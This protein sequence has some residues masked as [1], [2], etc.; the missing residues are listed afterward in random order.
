[1]KP[2]IRLS[3]AVM[4]ALAEAAADVY[5]DT[6][7]SAPA[8]TN[9]LAEVIVTA[10]RRTENAQNVPI[11]LQAL[12]AET[13]TQLN[14]TTF[15]DYIKY[16]PNVT[17]QGLGPGQNNIYMRGL[18][19]AF[20]EIQGAGTLETF[21]NVAVYLDDQ[22]V[23]LP[24]RNLDIYAADLERIEV[25]EGPQGT[26]FGAGAQ[27]GVV[28]YITNK[29]QLDVIAGNV[30]AGYAT[31]AH[32]NPSSNAEGM[33]NLPIIPGTLAVRGVVYDEARG[34]YIN[35]IS[36]TFARQPTD[37]GILYAYHATPQNMVSIN[38]NNLAAS[39]IN[40]VTYKGLRVSALY[41]INDDWNALLTQSYQDMEADGV[42]AEQA[43]NSTG[44]PQPQLTVQLY[45]PSWNKDRFE[46]TSLTIN[47][48]IGDLKAVYTGAYFVRN[49][50]QVQDY[51]NYARGPYMDY[52]QCV[53]GN[54]AN[55]VPPHCYTPSATW[56]DIERNTHLSHEVRL[57]TPD[58]WRV[59]A[60]GGLFQENYNI[61]EQVDWFYKTATDY[62]TLIAPPLG[63]FTKNGSVLQG[64][65]DPHP[66]KPV[67][68]N[69]PGA[70][71]VPGP[72][73]SNN[74]N[75]RNIND[76]FFNDITRGYTQ[77][78]AFGSLDFDVV[79]KKLTLTV[80]TRYYRIEDS[81]RGSS[82]GSFGCKTFGVMAV[83]GATCTKVINGVTVSPVSNAYNLDSLHF[84]TV[85]TG[86]KSRANLTFKVADDAL[87]YYTW[88]QGFRAGGFNR[89]NSVGLAS[90]L[91][92]SPLAVANGG[93]N[94]PLVYNPDSLINNELGWK[95]EWWERRVQWNGAIYQ[96]NWKN[97]QITIFDPG[98]TGNL[99][100]T[101]NGG[102]YKVK[103]LETSLTARVTHALTVSGGASWN[104]TELTQ[105][106]P[107]FWNNGTPINFS[108]LTFRGQPL[109]TPGGAVG[110]PLASSPPFQAN[111]RLRYDFTLGNYRAFCQLS[112]VH[113]GH[114]LAT[115]DTLT[116]DL[117]GNSIAYDLSAWTSY[118][119]ALGIAKDTWM[120]QLYGQNLT[121][122][123]ADL[124]E[125]Y[126]QWYLAESTSRPRT[127]GLKFSYKLSGK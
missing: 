67:T 115:T 116:R 86:F 104:H 70:V 81:D 90:P 109:S 69:L 96:E 4:A 101:A 20:T 112:G 63:Y 87:L 28:R 111:L 52:Y 3:H 80:G 66:G 102:E 41:Q 126:R 2:N 59:R 118:D 22:S 83:P 94:P 56:H 12:T 37:L 44:V 26:L 120:V 85:N 99:R 84:D 121:N 124:Y 105:A 47:G 68:F 65:N 5:A 92:S 123:L 73:T 114:S 11:T 25:L 40:P 46:N 54:A 110:S 10:Q 55:G 8:A 7:G 6:S 39:A 21:P 31:T 106:A 45:N 91:R 35:N 23:Q 60:L 75:V 79:P 14:V 42:F 9:E 78:A 50:E 30:D 97:T 88:S 13:L 18:A 53:S 36:G 48:R 103:G 74:P 82:V 61:Q 76:S 71:F 38:N 122:K 117:Q 98:I 34:G 24:G 108:Q 127:I 77:R 100:F 17:G 95:S 57:S 119:G 51:T 32:G 72:A 43:V 29:P 58:N 107:F 27:A 15:D 49:V 33:I 125:N 19:T 64:P 62:F 1:L 113:Q 16:L 89:P 93:W